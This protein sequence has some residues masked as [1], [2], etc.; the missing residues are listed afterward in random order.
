[1][2]LVWQLGVLLYYV[3]NSDQHPFLSTVNSN[4]NATNTI[5]NYETYEETVRSAGFIT[6]TRRNIL[7]IRYKKATGNDLKSHKLQ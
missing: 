4:W 2:A 5:Q 1:M 3:N 6:Q 7:L